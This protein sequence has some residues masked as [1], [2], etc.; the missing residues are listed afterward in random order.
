M[1]TVECAK[2]GHILMLLVM[3]EFI[4]DVTE[5]E[6]VVLQA[7]LKELLDS[8]SCGLCDLPHSHYL[9]EA[10]IRMSNCGC[11]Q[12]C[13]PGQEGK[14]TKCIGCP[15]ASGKKALALYASFK[16]ALLVSTENLQTLPQ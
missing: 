3:M 2:Q 5:T 8:C 15:R 12:G 14:D 13:G 9:C 1:P 10:K 7:G 4:Q 16:R 11:W 6:G